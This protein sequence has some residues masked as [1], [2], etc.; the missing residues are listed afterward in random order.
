[1]FFVHASTAARFLARGSRSL[2]W[3]RVGDGAAD[4]GGDLLVQQHPGCPV[5]LDTLDGPSHMSFMIRLEEGRWNLRV[6]SGG[7]REQ[8][9]QERVRV[10]CRM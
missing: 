1:V 3:R 8:V 5:D 10:G 9:Q 2:V 4:L 7:S 6:P